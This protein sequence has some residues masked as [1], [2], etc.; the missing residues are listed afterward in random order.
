MTSD[1][2]N[3]DPVTGECPVPAPIPIRRISYHQSWFDN[4]PSVEP[5]FEVNSSDEDV[6]PDDTSIEGSYTLDHG[7]EEGVESDDDTFSTVSS[8]HIDELNIKDDGPVVEDV[9]DDQDYDGDAETE[10]DD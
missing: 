2:E 9:E 8:V 7:Q 10:D 1:K 4:L 3:T 5:R 6:D